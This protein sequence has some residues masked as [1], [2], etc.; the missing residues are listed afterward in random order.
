[1]NDEWLMLLLFLFFYVLFPFV[2]DFAKNSMTLLASSV[3]KAFSC[4]LAD[5]IIDKLLIL[6]SHTKRFIQKSSLSSSTSYRWCLFKGLGIEICLLHCYVCMCVC[7][8]DL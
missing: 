7:A 1:M 6:F 2:P 8:V 3:I 5:R 4:L